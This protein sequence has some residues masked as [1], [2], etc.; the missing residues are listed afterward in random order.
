[1]PKDMSTY[2]AVVSRGTGDVKLLQSFHLFLQDSFRV[3]DL[4]D[5]AIG[6]IGCPQLTGNAPPTELQYFFFQWHRDNRPCLI[7]GW[8]EVQERSPDPQFTLKFDT[9]PPPSPAC[10]TQ[11]Q[12]CY[13]N[14]VCIS[15]GGCDRNLGQIGCQKCQ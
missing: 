6:C 7:E 4:E 2:R 14:P 10:S 9:T 15:T 8:V 1:V 12:P 13:T 3:S 11:P 5:Q